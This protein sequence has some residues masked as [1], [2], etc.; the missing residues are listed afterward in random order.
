[1]TGPLALYRQRVARGEIS[2]DPAQQRTVEALERL[3]RDFG[4]AGAAVGGLRLCP[5]I[6]NTPAHIERAALGVKSALAL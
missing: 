4:I 5:H 3:Y 2:S 1:M 6:Y